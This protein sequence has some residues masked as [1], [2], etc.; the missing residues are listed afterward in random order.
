MT[1][2]LNIAK[3]DEAKHLTFRLLPVLVSIVIKMLAQSKNR[4]LELVRIVITDIT[5]NHA[6]FGAYC[7]ERDFFTMTNVCP[8]HAHQAL[9]T[10]LHE[11]QIHA[12]IQDMPG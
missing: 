10:S 8:Y 7:Y 11:N 1:V 5:R 12:I 3:A 6:L 4:N 9:Y 2:M